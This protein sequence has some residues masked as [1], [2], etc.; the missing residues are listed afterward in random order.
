VDAYP[1]YPFK[2]H[3]SRISAGIVPPP[4]SIGEFTKTTQRI[5]VTILFDEIPGGMLLLPGM[6]VEVKIKIKD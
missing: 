5:P 6:S 1:S 2:G 3:V 4:F